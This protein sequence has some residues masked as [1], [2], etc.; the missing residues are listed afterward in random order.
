[1]E[2]K[3]KIDIRLGSFLRKIIVESKYT[4][5]EIAEALE[6]DDRT[7]QYFMTGERRPNQ[8]NLLKLLKFLQID[9]ADIPF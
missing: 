6:L 4:I 8:I 1:M 5:S 2:S 9:L 3:R 7:I